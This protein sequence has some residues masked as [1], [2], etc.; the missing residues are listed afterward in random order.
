MDFFGLSWTFGP[1]QALVHMAGCLEN[2]MYNN[3]KILF[4]RQCNLPKL[5]YFDSSICSFMEEKDLWP[6]DYDVINHRGGVFMNFLQTIIANIPHCKDLYDQEVTEFGKTE[7]DAV[8]SAL[9]PMLE[10]IIPMDNASMDLSVVEALTQATSAAGGLSIDGLD[11]L[12]G[13]AIH[14]VLGILISGEEPGLGI[15]LYR[16]DSFEHFGDYVDSKFLAKIVATFLKSGPS[17]F[18]IVA[19]DFIHKLI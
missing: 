10:L 13:H 16:F 6:L 1:K 11:E 7:K 12:G 5:Q 9:L 17:T 18:L 19:Y 3:Q 14:A 8:K 2:K 4:I 15:D